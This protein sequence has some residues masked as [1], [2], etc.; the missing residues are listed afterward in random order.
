MVAFSRF[1]W[2]SVTDFWAVDAFFVAAA[3]ADCFV[4]KSLL[5]EASA[6]LKFTS[7]FSV[8]VSLALML[9]ASFIYTSIT[10]TFFFCCFAFAILSFTLI[11][12]FFSSCALFCA[13]SR[14]AVV[15]LRV[16]DAV[17][18]ADLASERGF[19]EAEYAALAD[20]RLDFSAE[21]GAGA[22]AVFGAAFA[23]AAGATVAALAATVFVV[24]AA[25]VVVSAEAT[26]AL[27][28]SASEMGTIAPTRS[29][30]AVT[31]P[32]MA[33]LAPSKISS[34]LLFLGSL[35]RFITTW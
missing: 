18:A 15:L 35:D 12:S 34:L 19:W 25:G 16:E 22:G 10:W 13:A 17:A 4:L 30:A 23:F 32:T 8:S 29:V 31:V 33:F 28:T 7:D 26:A 14:A 27:A 21:R 3:S 11:N 2:A 6:L 5:S 1:V 20:S 24:V 9:S